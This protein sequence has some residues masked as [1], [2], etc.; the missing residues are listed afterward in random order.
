MAQ[1]LLDTN[2]FWE[3]LISWNN[4][5]LSAN[6]PNDLIQNQVYT[7]SISEITA[8][9]IYSV[10]GK[11]LRG[12]QKQVILCNRTVID[13]TICSNQWEKSAEKK[14]SPHEGQAILHII[15]AILLQKQVG[16]LVNIIPIDRTIISSAATLLELYANKYDFRSLDSIVA[17]TSQA[18]GFATVTYDT[19]LKNVLK[20]AQIAVYER[21]RSK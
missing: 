2:T 5:V 10:L 16:F 3:A 17:A 13:G 21:E 9:E 20:M 18:G 6:L 1:Y 11:H 7:F 8:M 4:G 19:K 12:K 14:L 15:R